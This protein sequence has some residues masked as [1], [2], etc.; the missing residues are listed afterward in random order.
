MHYT[1]CA[2]LKAA[3]KPM[4]SALR[5]NEKT[6]LVNYVYK[7]MPPVIKEIKQLCVYGTSI[8]KQLINTSLLARFN[9]TKPKNTSLDYVD[10]ISML[11]KLKWNC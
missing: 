6:Q 9:I 5:F 4:S 7:N 3:D 10:L 8:E 1:S 2:F 11:R